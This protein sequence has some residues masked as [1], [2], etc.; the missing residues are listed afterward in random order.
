MSLEA[1]RRK[2]EILRIINSKGQVETAELAEQMEVSTETIRRYFKQLEKDNNLKMVYGG[3]VKVSFDKKE[4]EHLKRE[5]LHRH[6]KDIIARR[7]A[8]LIE[9]DDVIAVDEGTTT[10]QLINYIMYKEN[11]TV[12]S[13]SLPFISELINYK[14]KNLF[15]GEIILIGGRVNARHKRSSGTIAVK[16]MD[17]FHIDKAFISASGIVND[18]GFT[19]FETEK[20]MLS[21]K[22]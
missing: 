11:L 15:S 13:S 2:K 9:D 5:V 21:Q 8:D 14:N 16:M 1:E 17:Y 20:G 4:P 10:F 6:E 7:A 22:Y 18:Y 19:D 12:I 3:A